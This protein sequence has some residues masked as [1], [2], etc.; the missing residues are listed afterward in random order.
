MPP[1][2]CRKVTGVNHPASPDV[3][4]LVSRRDGLD[5]NSTPSDISCISS[6]VPPGQ[7]MRSSTSGGSSTRPRLFM[8]VARHTASL[9]WC[10]A[11]RTRSCPLWTIS[12]TPSLIILERDAWLARLDPEYMQR[13]WDGFRIKSGMTNRG[14]FVSLCLCAKRSS[15]RRRHKPAR[16]P[17]NPPP[18][19]CISPPPA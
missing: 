11:N 15:R 1:R 10:H 3:I 9:T 2:S 14:S 18:P 16:A 7:P 12:R 19:P 8:I 13:R 17:R 4:S 6:T 5:R